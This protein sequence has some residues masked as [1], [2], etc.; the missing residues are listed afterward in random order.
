MSFPVRR[1]LSSILLDSFKNSVR[2]SINSMGMQ[3][4][5]FLENTNSLVPVSTNISIKA[6]SESFLEYFRECFPHSVDFTVLFKE[7][8]MQI[9]IVFDHILF[10]SFSLHSVPELKSLL[11]HSGH[12]V[13]L[14]FV[15]F[16][17]F[18]LVF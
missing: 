16:S 6:F 7:L 8:P 5:D 18:D 10:E 11:F 1:S 13:F 15:H 2:W 14:E 4:M 17:H 3:G 12:L 9:N